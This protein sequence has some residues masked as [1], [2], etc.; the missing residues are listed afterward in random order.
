M[1]C[2]YV[3]SEVSEKICESFNSLV[4]ALCQQRESL[5]SDLKSAHSNQQ[6][7]LTQQTDCLETLLLDVTNCCELTK[8]A[9][10]HGNETEVRTKKTHCEIN[11]T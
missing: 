11:Y 7:L 10:K 8:T 2:V 3:C 5:L 1:L 4:N 9:L 6:Q